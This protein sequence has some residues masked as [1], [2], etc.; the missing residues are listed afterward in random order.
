[1]QWMATLARCGLLGVR[2]G[3]ALLAFGLLC[4]WTGEASAQLTPPGLGDGKTAYW[5]ALGA[6]QGLG[7]R[8]RWE[9]M[10]YTGFGTI[11]HPNN[12]NL[13]EKPAI[14]ML[15]QEFYDR[16]RK[17]LAYSFALS[18]RRQNLYRNAYPFERDDPKGRIEFRLYGRFIH[19][20]HFGSV[21][22]GNAL[23]P[24]LRT[25]YPRSTGE[26]VLQFRLRFRQKVQWAVDEQKVHRII[27]SAEVLASMDKERG[28]PFGTFGYR[29]S[30]FCVYY[31]FSPKNLAWAFDI[32]YMNNLLGSSRP[33]VVQYL[34]IDAIWKN[35][36]GKPPIVD[37]HSGLLH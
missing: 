6:R 13:F 21:Q 23:R 19:T 5:M 3:M 25:F 30:R 11:S 20:L 16:F 18:L 4:T 36:F 17:D 1:M 34:A 37:S 15:N 8:G 24:E 29:E 26:E 28:A 9:S 22:L 7:T 12:Y 14:F 27:G 35:P 33:I 2:G 32:G 31:A 10:S